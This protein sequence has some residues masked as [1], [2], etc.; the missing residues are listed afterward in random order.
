MFLN[1]IAINGQVLNLNAVVLIE[2]ETEDAAEG[3]TATPIAVVH[4]LQGDEYRFEGEDATALFDRME[5][6]VQV[7]DAALANALNAT[8]KGA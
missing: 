5:L 3:E 7:N 2:D 6:I 4:T 8:G 1:F